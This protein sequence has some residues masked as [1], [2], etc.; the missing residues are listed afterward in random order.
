MRMHRFVPWTR[1]HM[2]FTFT[3]NC[4]LSAECEV[5]NCVVN[6]LLSASHTTDKRD[7]LPVFYAC[8]DGSC[9]VEIQSMD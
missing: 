1:P 4:G 6:H 2:A 3:M 5:S 8:Y 9:L 7:N